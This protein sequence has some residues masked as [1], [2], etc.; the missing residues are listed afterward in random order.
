MNQLVQASQVSVCVVRQPIQNSIKGRS[1]VASYEPSPKL[2]IKNDP[3]GQRLVF[4]R[5]E[6]LIISGYAYDVTS[7]S[8]KLPS[9]CEYRTDPYLQAQHSLDFSYANP[10]SPSHDC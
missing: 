2:Q 10:V 1:R 7:R 6:K 9:E 3:G 4:P 8:E 5:V